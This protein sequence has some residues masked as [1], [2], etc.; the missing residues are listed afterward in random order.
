MT[1]EHK[2]RRRK[3][4][5]EER[6]LWRDVTTSI[7]PL[8]RRGLKA[9]ASVEAEAEVE[10]TPGAPATA[11]AR[12][13]PKPP[14]PVPHAQPALAPLDRRARQRIARGTDRIDARIDLHG[15]TQAQAHDALVR[16]LRRAQDKGARIVLVITGKGGGMDD[17]G[18]G[19]L[20]R[21]VPLW[22]ALPEFRALVLSVETASAAH[23]GEGALY[24]R[25]RR[26]K[27]G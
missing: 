26:A 13:A 24:V 2:P 14:Y 7:S 27:G 16:F 3:L 12:P 18:R 4:S 6:A 23:G 19:V 22:L 1:S 17:T 25:M 9:K 10:Q 5:T 21:Q 20:R 11:P 8:R 15:H